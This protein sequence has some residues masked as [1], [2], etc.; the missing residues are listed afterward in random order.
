MLYVIKVPSSGAEPR[1]SR[2]R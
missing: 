1:L 2:E